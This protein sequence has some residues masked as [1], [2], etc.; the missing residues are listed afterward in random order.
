MKRTKFLLGAIVIVAVIGYLI[1]SSLR[2]ATQYYLTVAELEAQGP[3][4][5]IVRVNG[6]VDGA[7]I[8]YDPRTLT[9]HFD[10]MDDSGRLPVVYN[11]VMPDMLREGAD[12]VIEGKYREDGVF[13][14]NPNGL[15]LKCP[16]KYEEAATSTVRP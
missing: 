7:S 6:L 12:A 5:R 4:N 14:V 10:L 1:F 16:S 9:I 13:E 2:G 3:S 15:L 11:D 8:Q